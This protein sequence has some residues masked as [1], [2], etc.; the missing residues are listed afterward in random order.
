M[1]LESGIHFQ[2]HLCHNVYTAY[3]C[4]EHCYNNVTYCL[5]DVDNILIESMKPKSEFLEAECVLTIKLF[6]III[7]YYIFNHFHAPTTCKV[8]YNANRDPKLTVDSRIIFL[9]IPREMDRNGTKPKITQALFYTGSCH[10][11]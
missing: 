9:N 11:S 7:I 4:M 5:I 6:Q 8:F 10:T 3:H 1:T 2:S